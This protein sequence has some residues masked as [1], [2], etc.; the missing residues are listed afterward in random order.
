MEQFSLTHAIAAGVYMFLEHE[1]GKT[2]H[3]SLIGLVK[4]GFTC[5]LKFIGDLKK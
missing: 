1:L 4:N 5:I 3:G 2:E